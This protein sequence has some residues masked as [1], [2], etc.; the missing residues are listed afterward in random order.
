MSLVVEQTIPYSTPQLQLK[1][2]KR[3][4]RLLPLMRPSIKVVGITNGQ[5]VMIDTAL[6]KSKDVLIT[7]VVR[8]GNF[9]SKILSESHLAAFVVEQDEDAVSAGD[10]TKTLSDSGFPIE[11]GVVVIRVGN[12]QDLKNSSGVLELMV[13]GELK[14]DHALS[15]LSAAKPDV[16]ASLDKI[17]ALLGH[18]V[19]SS[20]NTTSRFH[21][22]K[23]ENTPSVAHGLDMVAFNSAKG[24]IDRDLSNLLVSSSSDGNGK[25]YSIHYSDINGLSR[26]ENNIIAHEISEYLA[27]N[28]LKPYIT[29]STILNE[30]SQ[31]RGWSI[32]LCVIPPDFLTPQ[33]KPSNTLANTKLAFSNASAITSKITFSDPRVRKMITKGCERVIKEEATITEYDTIVGDGDCG[34]T[35]RDGAKQVLS[36]IKQADLSKLPSTLSDLVDDLEV[37]MGGTSGA[38]YCI[39]LSSLAQSLRDSSTFAEAL[40]GAL[41]SLLMYTNARLGDR[42][43]LDCLIPFVETLKKTGDAEMALKGAKAGVES[44]KKLEAKLGRSSYL[45]EAVTRGV[46]DPGA[47]GL[48][49]LLEGMVGA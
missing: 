24:S 26:L 19:K 8:V 16:R 46:P 47:Y 1:D 40:E 39:F 35:L 14:V 20:A 15:L 25:V 45:D 4:S 30:Q 7:S 21:T 38:L 13:E 34:Y 12:N 37:N 36:Y 48:L 32:S 11:N 41:N 6:A 31:A 22:Q 23:C 5:T 33:S 42:T 10:L 2:P 49:M 17:E 18:F 29:Q 9:S 3:W 43:C 28:N 27:K 44:T